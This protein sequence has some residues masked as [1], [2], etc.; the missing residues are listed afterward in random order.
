MAEG[1]KPPRGHLFSWKFHH[2]VLKN[3]ACLWDTYEIS[4]TPLI[5]PHKNPLCAPGIPFLLILL[6]C[7]ASD[8]NTLMFDKLGF[9][10]VIAKYAVS[11]K[12]F[13]KHRMRMY[14][15]A[16]TA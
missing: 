4:W 9:L 11:F 12:R 16:I 13:S 3:L 2:P 10:P 15:A 6:I 7:V 5:I 8:P 14:A 1:D